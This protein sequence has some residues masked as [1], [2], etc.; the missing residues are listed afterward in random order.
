M[1][2]KQLGLG[3][4]LENYKRVE[5][6]NYSVG[7]I[8]NWGP[9]L[10]FNSLFSVVELA[11]VS[12]RGDSLQYEGC[13]MTP[14]GPTTGV[15]T[16]ENRYFS[17]ASNSEYL[18]VDNSRDDQIN[19]NAYS[20]TLVAQ[21]TWNDV[22]A[23]VNLSPS[24]AWSHDFEGNSH[25]AGSYVEGNKAYTIGLDADYQN[26]LQAGIAYTDFIDSGI[27]D[28]DNIGVNVKYSF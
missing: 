13:V 19:R 27:D 24:V 20:Y 21:G 16:Y 26:T 12:Y 14:T 5:M 9:S 25:Q 17:G 18:N 4:T 6:Y 7:S 1:G 2:G 28:R 8:Q 10:G 3:D 15:C 11:G 22:F 23:G